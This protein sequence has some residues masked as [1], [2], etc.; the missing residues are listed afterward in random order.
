MLVHQLALTMINGVGPKLAR[1]LIDHLGSVEEVFSPKAPF[2]KV[3]GIG[4]VMASRLRNMDT[5]P[6]LKRAEKEI[7]FIYRHDITALFIDD[8][9]YPSRLANCEDAPLLI[10][11]KGKADLETPKAL[12]IV[13]TRR[14]SDYGKY[15]CEKLVKDIAERHP[16]TLIISGLA[17]G[18]DICAHRAALKY[19]LPTVAVLAHGLD[20]IYPPSHRSTATKICEQGALVTE[21]MTDTNPDKP[22][23]VRRNRIAAGLCDAVI[24]VESA[25]K[26]GALITAGLAAGYS[27][28]VLAFPG[29]VGDEL[30][31]GCNRL[32][33]ANKAALIETIDDLEYA[34]GWES[35]TNFNRATQGY[36]FATPDTPEE[37]QIMDLLHEEKEMNLNL[38]STATGIPIPR[39]SAILLE[40]EFKGLI[41]SM[42]GGMYRML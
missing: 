18:I 19:G 23:F 41:K 8:P 30:S 24:V 10:F 14:A 12:S 35:P 39:L 32:I 1:L 34:L 9:E 4:E 25:E 22:N 40:M 15:L 13:G 16:G 42:P 11:I 3:P 33:K 6:L 37:K 38:I 36:L 27:R 26:G 17:Y 29:R 28:D 31:A 7:E 2:E 20:R 21:F 5:R